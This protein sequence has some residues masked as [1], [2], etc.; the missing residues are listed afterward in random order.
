MEPVLNHADQVARI[1]R[2]PA[3][4]EEGREQRGVEGGR[5]ELDGAG[6]FGEGAGAGGAGEV[7]GS[8][9]PAQYGVAR[10]EH[11]STSSDGTQVRPERARDRLDDRRS[12]TVG[13]RAAHAIQIRAIKTGRAGLF[14][15][16][17]AA[18]AR[19]GDN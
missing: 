7:V 13:A 3:E 11:P 16:T 6:D 9:A 12:R 8:G 14:L 17:T 2:R 1:Y 4:R 19:T 5:V 15:R 18:R 10:R